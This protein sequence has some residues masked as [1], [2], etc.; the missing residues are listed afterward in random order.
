VEDENQLIEFHQ[1]GDGFSIKGNENSKLLFLS[2][3]P[4]KEHVTSW[5]PYVMNTQTEIMEAMRD[6]QKGKM[7]FLPVS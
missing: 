4:I 7:G 3:V 5:G 6:Y 1:D 2:G